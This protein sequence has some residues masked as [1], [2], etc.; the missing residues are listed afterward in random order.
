M[1]LSDALKTVAVSLG[2]AEFTASF[3]DKSLGEIRWSSPE[4][5]DLPF[6]DEPLAP[7]YVALPVLESDDS[8]ETPSSHPENDDTSWTTLEEIFGLDQ[9]DASGLLFED[10]GDENLANNDEPAHASSTRSK[11]RTSSSPVHPPNFEAQQHSQ[12][13]LSLAEQAGPTNHQVLEA[14]ESKMEPGDGNDDQVI[15][16]GSREKSPPA[17]R[18]M[19]KK[20][21][22]DAIPAT[23]DQILLLEQ[24]TPYRWNRHKLCWAGEEEARSEVLVELITLAGVGVRPYGL[25]GVPVELSWDENTEAFEGCDLAD[26]R[27]RIELETMREMVLAGGRGE[28]VYVD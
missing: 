23:I 18:S 26:R 13:N 24:G 6:P 2:Q 16:L 14:R 12:E 22:L 5:F 15:Y 11:D 9:E 10:A 7:F 21:K 19:A 3:V 25:N 17:E 28:C 1:P 27:L 20:R 4:E 8:S